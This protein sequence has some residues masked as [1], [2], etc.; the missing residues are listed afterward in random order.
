MK[1]CFYKHFFILLSMYKMNNGDSN[2]KVI[3]IKGVHRVDYRLLIVI[4]LNI[5]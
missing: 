2:F 5:K 1:C 3:Q 4:V